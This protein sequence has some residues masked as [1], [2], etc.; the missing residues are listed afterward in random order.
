MTEDSRRSIP[1]GTHTALF[2]GMPSVSGLDYE[3]PVACVA[4]FTFGYPTWVFD[5]GPDVARPE[6]LFIEDEAAL[7]EWA[8]RNFEHYE[9]RPL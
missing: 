6:E 9:I 5:D 4:V 8:G 2:V 7:K 1:E 3:D